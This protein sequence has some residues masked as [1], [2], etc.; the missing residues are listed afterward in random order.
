MEYSQQ[1]DKTKSDYFLHLPEEIHELRN[2]MEKV[3]FDDAAKL[4]SRI[5]RHAMN[6]GVGDL[7]SACRWLEEI[8]KRKSLDELLNAYQVLEVIAGS[9]SHVYYC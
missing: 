5:R 4:A 2:A 9:Y 7:A 1:L 3:A 6:F 8:C